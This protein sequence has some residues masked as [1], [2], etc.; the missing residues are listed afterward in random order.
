MK[1]INVRL[2]VLMTAMMMFRKENSRMSRC[3]SGFVIKNHAWNFSTKATT[4]AINIESRS[5]IMK[6]RCFSQEYLFF[7]CIVCT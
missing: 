7:V 6:S 3:H 5:T 2:A 4:N 1:R